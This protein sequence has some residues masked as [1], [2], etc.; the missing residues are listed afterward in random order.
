MSAERAPWVR[1]ARRQRSRPAAVRGPVLI[2]PCSR[3]RPLAMAGWRQEPWI[4][5]WAQQ[6][7]AARKSPGRLPLRSRPRRSGG[8]EAGNERRTPPAC[9]SRTAGRCPAGTAATMAVVMGVSPGFGVSLMFSKCSNTSA[10]KS[11]GCMSR[12]FT[13]PPNS[14]SPGLARRSGKRLRQ[15]ALWRVRWI[16]GSSPAMTIFEDRTNRGTAP[17]Q[18]G[19]FLSLPAQFGPA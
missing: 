14:S 16:A 12:R 19:Q 5:V 4:R 18:L 2:P 8:R 7:G 3:Q 11:R 10:G 6:R 17:A 13:P 9:R 15:V 1:R